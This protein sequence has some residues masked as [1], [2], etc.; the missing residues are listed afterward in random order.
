MPRGS[1]SA[2][3]ACTRSASETMGVRQTS[4]ALAQAQSSLRA[5]STEAVSRKIYFSNQMRLFR[6]SRTRL[7]LNPAFSNSSDRLFPSHPILVN[8]ILYCFYTN[9][10]FSVIKFNSADFFNSFTPHWLEIDTRQSLHCARV[11]TGL[12]LSSILARTGSR[13]KTNR[14]KR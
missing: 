5:P 1:R 9:F 10:I 2:S 3:C 6:K 7:L 12:P 4:L 8:E 13:G 11:G 14:L